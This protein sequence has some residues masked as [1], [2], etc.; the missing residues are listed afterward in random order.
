MSEGMIPMKMRA[1]GL[2]AAMLLMVTSGVLA[3]EPTGWR[4]QI[5][6]YAWFVGIEGTVTVDGREVEFEKSPRDL[7]DYV[8]SAVG[9][10]GDV[11]YD[12]WVMLAQLYSFSL[13]TDNVGVED[14]S[15]A[16]S[17][18]SDFFFAEVAAGRRIDGWREGQ[19]L[20]LLVGV[21]ALQVKNDLEEYDVGSFSREG[22]LV[23][24]LA[25]VRGSTP[26][27]P[28]KISGLRLVAMAA[29][30]GGG[31]SQLVYEFQPQLQYQV[32]YRAAVRAGYRRVGWRVDSDQNDDQLK[33][34]LA[35]L[36]FGVA[37]SF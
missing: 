19:T 3:E 22:S 36:V 12:R 29:V 23:D 25:S 13:D 6:P 16:G 1:A 31:D 18:E 32:T 8:E 20:D 30:G 7:F 34:S 33:F 5:V 14:R 27:L 35:G 21:R 28:S 15:A 2:I 17:L 11:Q 24:P 26:I 4:G 37:V 10:A 9:V